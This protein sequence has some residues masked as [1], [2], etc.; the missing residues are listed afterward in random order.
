MEQNDRKQRGGDVVGAIQGRMMA[1]RYRLCTAE[2][3]ADFDDDLRREIAVIED[4][5][6]R[7]HAAEMLREWRYRLFLSGS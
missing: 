6:V 3:R 7:R 2:G 1:T 4:E 5:I